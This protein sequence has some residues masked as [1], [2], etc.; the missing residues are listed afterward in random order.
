M[1]RVGWFGIILTVSVIATFASNYIVSPYQTYPNG[2]AYSGD[3]NN[4]QCLSDQPL[5]PGNDCSP[6]H[7]I[8][9]GFPF[10][11]VTTNDGIYYPNIQAGTFFNILGIIGNFIF[12][13]IVITL[14]TFIWIKVRKH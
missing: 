9:Y 1:K 11:A 5:A 6:V 12:Y 10:R 7:S 4:P 3:T 2:V 8:N 13:L 14:I